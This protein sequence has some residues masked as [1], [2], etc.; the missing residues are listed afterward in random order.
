MRIIAR[1]LAALLLGALSIFAAGLPASAAVAGCQPATPGYA[2]SGVCSVTVTKAQAVCLNGVVQLSYE[3]GTEPT[4]ASSVDLKWINPAGPAFTL[5]GQ[6][7]T[8]TVVWPAS[9]PKVALDVQ[10]ISGAT[11][12]VR[13]DPT[14]ASSSC[15]VSKVLSVTVPTS[16]SSSSS[17]VLSATGAEVLPFVVTGGG[18]LL[19]GAALLVVRATRM[20]RLSAQN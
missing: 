20:R 11:A 12:T 17:R 8:G 2:G 7:L 16:P 19:V 5:T 10:F 9:I 6:P 4:V 1:T 3:V 14:A 18:L 13:V 15:T